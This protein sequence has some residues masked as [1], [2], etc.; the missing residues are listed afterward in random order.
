M[1]VS[2]LITSWNTKHL[3]Q[4]CLRS[5]RSYAPAFPFEIIVV[6]NGSS[7]ASAAMVEQEFPDVQLIKRAMNIGYA[8]GNNIG[9]KRSQGEYVLLLGSDTEVFSETIQR[10]AEYLDSRPDVGIVACRLE[11]PDGTLQHSCKQFPTVANAVAMYCSLHFLNKE[12]LMWGFDHATEREVDQPDA[13]CVMI[14]RTALDH[15]IFDERFSILYNDVDLCQ[16]VS[17]KGWKIM[18]IPSVKILHHG[19]Q[20]TK[21]ASPNVR[22][23]MYQNILL[24]YQT[25]FGSAAR[26]LLS[27][28]LFFRYLLV[29]KSFSG[30]S[31][32]YSLQKARLS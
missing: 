6:D 10:M 7:D 5:I 3:L 13:T 16:R 27:P 17:R 29:A 26:I 20:S 18:Y 9:F 32:F 12:Y 21:Q 28:I 8:G 2:I 31:L 14:R 1:K 4:A 30:F 23:V 15:R 11:S 19:S 24:Y 25:Y 22:L